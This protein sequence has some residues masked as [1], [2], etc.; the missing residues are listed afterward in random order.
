MWLINLWS[1]LS[2]ICSR[3]TLSGHLLTCVV[4]QKWT[5]LPSAQHMNL[6]ANWLEVCM[7]QFCGR[8]YNFK[9][10]MNVTRKLY[11]AICYWLF[12]VNLNSTWSLEF[13]GVPFYIMA[14][15]HQIQ[16]LLSFTCENSHIDIGAQP[17][18]L[19]MTRRRSLALQS[20]LQ[21]KVTEDPKIVLSREQTLQLQVS[22]A[23]D[24]YAD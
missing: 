16:Q 24:W 9:F 5:W 19:R 6:L 23:S 18:N 8:Q 20:T 17:R 1:C 21:S 4:G 11:V 10:D 14:T 13:V 3:Q 15:R 12:H 2:A 7:C 22:S